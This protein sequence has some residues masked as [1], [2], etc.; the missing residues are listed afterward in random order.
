MPTNQSAEVADIMPYYPA[1]RSFLSNHHGYYCEECLASRL[2]LSV[3]KIRRSVGQRTL[4]EITI[5]YRICQS[6]LDEKG[7]FALRTTA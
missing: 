4:A 2:N 1:I 5:A 3:D 7:V 6:C